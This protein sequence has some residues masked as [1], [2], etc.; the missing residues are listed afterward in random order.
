[1]HKNSGN[2]FLFRELHDPLN[3]PYLCCGQCV[4]HRIID[5]INICNVYK[6]IINAFVIYV[7]VFLFYFNKRN[8]KCRKSFVEQLEWSE[9]YD[10]K[11]SFHLLF[12]RLNSEPELTDS[13]I[14]I[15]KTVNT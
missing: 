11:P 7:N 2:I 9:A 6:K 12:C 8:M 3:F 4:I 5:V 15:Y 10:E 14:E 1:M 13:D